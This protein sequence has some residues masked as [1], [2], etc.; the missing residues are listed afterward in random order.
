MERTFVE[1]KPFTR[2]WSQA[3]CTDDDLR[4]LQAHLAE[5]PKAGDLI[6]GAGGVRKVRWKSSS[7]NE[8]K[9]GGV[10]VFYVDHERKATTYLLVTLDKKEKANLSKEER[11]ELGKLAKDLVGG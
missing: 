11:T 10:R 4:G 6:E 2:S 3:G 7:R 9:S 1:T 8:G 5:N